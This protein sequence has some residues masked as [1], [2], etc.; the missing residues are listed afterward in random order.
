MQLDLKGALVKELVLIGGGHSHVHVLRML[1]MKPIEGLQITLITRDVMTPYSGMIPGH[2]AGHYTREEC[3]IDLR[4]LANFCNARLVHGSAT[5]L[6]RANK[7]PV[8]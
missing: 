5:G 8:D 4:K 2:I 3:H 1:G 7:V 6:D